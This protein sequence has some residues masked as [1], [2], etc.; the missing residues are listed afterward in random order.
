MAA[1]PAAFSAAVAALRVYTMASGGQ[2]PTFKFYMY[3]GAQGGQGTFLV[4]VIVDIPADVAAVTVKTDALHLGDAFSLFF[5]D[6][7]MAQGAV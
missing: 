4:E 1:D 7:L 2:H 3:A 5:A 6:A